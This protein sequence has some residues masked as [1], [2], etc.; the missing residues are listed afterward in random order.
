[1]S[2]KFLANLFFYLKIPCCRRHPLPHQD[3]C[4]K[5]TLKKNRKNKK[6]IFSRSVVQN[7]FS[8]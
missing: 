3:P 2:S 1:M 4:R 6:I 5:G 7:E 8:L